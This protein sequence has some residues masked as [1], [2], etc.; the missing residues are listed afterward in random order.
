MDVHIKMSE[1]KASQFFEVYHQIDMTLSNIDI[2]PNIADDTAIVTGGYTLQ[3]SPKANGR[4]EQTSGKLTLVF[5]NEA[6]NVAD[7]S[8]RIKAWHSEFEGYLKRFENGTRSV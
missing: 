4:V 3:Y 7:Y 8:R 1:T 2:H 5:A 6:G